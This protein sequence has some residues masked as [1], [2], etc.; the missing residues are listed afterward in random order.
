ME[1][2]GYDPLS[3]GLGELARE[4]I[5]A[6]SMNRLLDAAAERIEISSRRRKRVIRYGAAG[7]SFL[8]ILLSLLL[9]PVSYRVTIG[10]RITARWSGPESI[11]PGVENSLHNLAGCTGL[12]FSTEGKSRYLET[13]Y[14]GSD[15]GS[16]HRGVRRILSGHL[17]PDVDVTTHTTT[18]HRQ[19]GGNL[20]AAMTSGRL[21]IIGRGLDNAGLEDAMM[22]RI[23]EWGAKHA[24]VEI[25]IMPDGRRLF[26]IRYED[27]PQDSLY[28]DIEL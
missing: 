7:C 16:F 21:K 5:P 28:L 11:G 23:E 8:L 10:A 25:T 12:K 18:V 26:D 9:V 14:S 22:K 27:P 17:G 4:S 1:H 24:E 13:Y 19:V 20:L 6:G 15:V 2:R 3:R